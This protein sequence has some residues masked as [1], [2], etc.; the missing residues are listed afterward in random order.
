MDN[1]FAPNL[2]NFGGILNGSSQFDEENELIISQ[3][4]DWF[5][6]FIKNEPLGL[7]SL[8]KYDSKDVVE[9]GSFSAKL[10]P[11]PT[12]YLF[13]TLAI[14]IE[15]SITLPLSRVNFLKTVSVFFFRFVISLMSFQSDLV[16]F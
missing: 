13:S 9:G 16:L 5:V 7:F 4:S 6:G 2:Y 3:I 15:F 1:G 8:R 10:G 12:K 11:T 14:S